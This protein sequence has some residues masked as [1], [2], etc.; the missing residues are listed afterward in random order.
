MATMTNVRMNVAMSG[1]TPSTPTFAKIAVK[2]A[3]TADKSA[4]P[5]QP[6]AAISCSSVLPLPVTVDHADPLGRSRVYPRNA[7]QSSRSHAGLLGHQNSRDHSRRDRRRHRH[8]DHGPG[9]PDRERHFPVGLDRLGGH[10]NRSEEISSLPLLVRHRR[11]HDRRNDHGRFRDPFV[12]YRLHGRLADLVRIA[13]G[14]A[15]AMVLVSRLGVGR[16][17]NHAKGGSILLG[18]HHA[19]SDV[20]DSAWRLDRRHRRSRLRRRGARVCR[21]LITAALYY[22]TDVPRVLLFWAAFILT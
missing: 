18:R 19:F 8:H 13:H 4:Q 5:C 14:R 17:G 1:S 7:E 11:L 15:R 12:G 9:L 3:N 6:I 16:D 20:G 10:P 22:W 21:R 2:A